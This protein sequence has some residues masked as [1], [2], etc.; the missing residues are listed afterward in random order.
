[1]TVG[2]AGG[3]GPSGCRS[4]KLSGA[5]GMSSSECD[6]DA[7]TG[8]RRIWGVTGADI[9]LA[10]YRPSFSANTMSPAVDGAH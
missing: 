2:V 3:E 5:K 4:G 1:M 9:M 8:I 7:S 6:S 10:V